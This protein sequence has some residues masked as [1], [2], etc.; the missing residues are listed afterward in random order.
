VTAHFRERTIIIV[1]Y[2]DIPHNYIV[3]AMM[4]INTI[5]QIARERG[6]DVI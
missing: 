3:M 6:V 4:D 5:R 2:G 1:S